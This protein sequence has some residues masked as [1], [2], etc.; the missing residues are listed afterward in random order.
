MVDNGRNRRNGQRNKVHFVHFVYTVHTVHCPFPIGGAMKLL[1]MTGL[2]L[3]TLA[4][5][6]YAA[7]LSDDTF[8][9]TLASYPV[10]P[11][12]TA[13]AAS[14]V[15]EPAS[16]A[17]SITT[18]LQRRVAS[19]AVKVGQKV[20]QGEILIELE[21]GDLEAEL[22]QRKA[23][24]AI[25]QAKWDRLAALP[26][27]EDIKEADAAVA[28]A[29]VALD[30]AEESQAR[31]QHLPDRRALSQE[32]ASDIERSVSLA[33]ARLQE[34]EAKAAKVKEGA[35]EKDKEIA[36]LEIALAKSA[37]AEMEEQIRQTIIRSPIAGQVL[38]LN[39]HMGEYPT[40]LPA[41]LPLMVVGDTDALTLK[42]SINQ[43]DTPLFSPNEPAFAYPRGYGE[44]K[45]PLTFLK[46]SP[47]L[48]SKQNF[49]G[50][51]TDKVDT[52]VLQVTYAIEGN[53]P[54]LYVGQQMDVFIKSTRSEG[55]HQ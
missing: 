26:R 28:A 13:I 15:V 16:E 30:K 31:L 34:A 22:A 51:I 49:T 3:H 33:K 41:A 44:E 12:P 38:A 37:V 24:L 48:V 11:F 18:P 55:A 6:L 47:M 1:Y 32:Q 36:K 35:W 46:L 27:D 54:P 20:K 5:S 39:V 25:Q 45:F 4:S 9:V 40:S 10:P 29:Q 17:I 19:I 52:R 23:A 50:E 8:K 21:R 2:A 53:T 43:F 14:G 42:V 7:P